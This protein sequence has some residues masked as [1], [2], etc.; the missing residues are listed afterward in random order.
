MNYATLL[1]AVEVIAREA[2]DAIMMV[3]ARD[4]S[5]Q[6]KADKSPLTEADKAAHEIIAHR[7][8]ELSIEGVSEPI[9]V[10]SEEDGGAFAGIDG[11]GRYWLVDPLDG[12]KEFIKRNGEF[13]VNIAL[14]EHG[15]PVLGV[16]VA[17]ALSVA[18]LAARGVGAFKVDEQGKREPITV[19]G[20]PAE[21]QRWRVVGSRSHPSPDLA[22]WLEKLGEHDMVPMGSSL[23]LCLIAEGQADVYPRLGPTCLWDT[24]AAQ[25]VVEVA[26]GRVETLAGEPLD[27]SSPDQHLNPYFVVWGVN[28]EL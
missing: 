6:E 12:T 4:F 2:G 22:A 13:T 10:L 18:Y 1:D 25:A 8:N 26:G 11:Q 27:Y 19:A 5:Y 3:Y 24:G 17:P 14:I 15:K 9:P 16:V 21:G 23:K 7:L 20:T 28:R